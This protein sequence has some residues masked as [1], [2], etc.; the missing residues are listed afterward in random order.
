MVLEVEKNPGLKVHTHSHACFCAKDSGSPESLCLWAGRTH[1]C[2]CPPTPTQC[3]SL[4]LFPH[5]HCTGPIHSPGLLEGRNPQGARIQAR[6]KLGSLQER[7]PEQESQEAVS[8]VAK[9]CQAAWLTQI[10]NEMLP[11]PHALCTTQ[12]QGHH[13][14]VSTNGTPRTQDLHHHTQWP[15]HFCLNR[16]NSNMASP[17]LWTQLSCRPG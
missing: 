2:R 4:G 11:G 3:S 14:R 13:H 16:S 5:F 15:G 7:S 17:I 10:T 1:H 9:D 12:L 6:R 8:K